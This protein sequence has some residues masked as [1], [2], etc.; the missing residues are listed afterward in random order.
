MHSTCSVSFYLSM[1]QVPRCYMPWHRRHA[2]PR[3][4]ASLHHSPFSHHDDALRRTPYHGRAASRPSERRPRLLDSRSAAACIAYPGVAN[5]G[6][7]AVFACLVL[8]CERDTNRLILTKVRPTM[9]GVLAMYG[10]LTISCVKTSASAITRRLCAFSRL[11]ILSS[12][13]A[14]ALYLGRTYNMGTALS[15]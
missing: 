11:D 2:P 5:I 7:D 3:V 8:G 10:G 4:G 14:G 15:Q 6:L 9:P 12:A 1:H 13:L